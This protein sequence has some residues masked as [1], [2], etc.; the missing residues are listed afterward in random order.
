M[1]SIIDWKFKF[2]VRYR[3]VVYRGKKKKKRRKTKQR[4]S[5]NRIIH[6]WSQMSS[7]FLLFSF[8]Q[9][10][11]DSFEFPMIPIR[12]RRSTNDWTSSLQTSVTSHPSI[13][14]PVH[15]SNLQSTS[16]SIYHLESLLLQALPQVLTISTKARAA[17][18]TQ[19]STSLCWS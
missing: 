16:P 10:A 5:G 4:V 11:R 1:Y 9:S 19:R 14:L 3:L 2:V 6:R 17:R 15:L 13:R 12:L 8:R 18:A 7:R